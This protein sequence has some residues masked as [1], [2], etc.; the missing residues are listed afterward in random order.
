MADPAKVPSKPDG[1]PKKKLRHMVENGSYYDKKSGLYW[2]RQ[3][4]RCILSTK[5]QHSPNA[6]S[7]ACWR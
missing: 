1:T 2:S 3:T 6:T 7:R 5:S 4:A